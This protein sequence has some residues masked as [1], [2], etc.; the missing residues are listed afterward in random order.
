MELT[1]HLRCARDKGVPLVAISAPDYDEVI[2]KLIPV[3]NEKEP[4]PVVVWDC[5]AGL[6]AKVGSLGEQFLRDK[7]Q[8]LNGTHTLERMVTW[9][10]EHLPENGV[11]FAVN[12]HMSLRS[13]AAIQGVRNL[14][15]P[16]KRSGCMFVMIGQSMTVPSELKGDVVLMD[17]EYPTV[18]RIEAIQDGLVTDLEKQKS[19]KIPRPKQKKEAAEKLKGMTAFM[20]E[21]ASAMALSLS[22][23]DT[24]SLWEQKI[25]AIQAIKGF[26]VDKD[27]LTMKDMGGLNAIRHYG[28]MLYSPTAKESPLIVVRI[29]EMDKKMGIENE[30]GTST[31]GNLQNDQLDVILN[32]MEDNGWG[33]LFALGHPGTGKTFFAKCL[34]NTYGA[35]S[36]SWDINGT[37]SKWVGESEEN[38]RENVKALKAMGGSRVFFVATANKIT[39]IPASL[40]RRFWMGIYFFDLPDK[41]EQDAVW[42]ICFNN[43]GMKRPKEMPD[44]TNW[45]QAEIRNCVELAWRFNCTPIEASKFFLPTFKSDAEGVKS[46]REHANGRYM[47]ASYEGPFQLLRP[48]ENNRRVIR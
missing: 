23:F 35:L 29:E 14:R 31:A 40:R 4:G 10:L 8:T 39:S 46:L 33:G 18:E 17:E 19:V 37:R 21:Q 22:G 36:M 27:H 12:A 41:A 43:K 5:S 25:Q 11:I 3:I 42:T 16:Y 44:Y 6:R 32:A 38:I 2:D 48:E 28:D 24:T 7:T 26:K 13:A 45:T 47:S 30:G 9:A 20:A 34:A 15:D 1:E